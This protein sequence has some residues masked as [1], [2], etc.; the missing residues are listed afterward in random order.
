MVF[1]FGGTGDDFSAS[2]DASSYS[3][4]FDPYV[5]SKYY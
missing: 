2:S 5:Y 1:G 3:Y 4:D